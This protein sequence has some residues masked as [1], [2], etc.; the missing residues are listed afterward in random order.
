VE[1][2]PSWE[3]DSHS[4]SQIP[5]LLWNP[6]IHYRIHNSPPLVSDLSQM[7]PVHISPTYFPKI[8]SNII[9]SCTPSYSLIF[10]FSD[11]NFVRISHLSSACYIPCPPH[12]PWFDHPNNFWWSVQ[13]MKLLIM[14]CFPAKGTWIWQEIS[15]EYANYR[16]KL[17][18][19]YY[20]T[21]IRIIIP[22]PHDLPSVLFHSDSSSTKLVQVFTSPWL[23]HVLPISFLI[24][25]P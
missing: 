18:W 9:L 23:L 12:P 3:A 6:K 21:W 14:Q 8:H 17:D 19:Y 10:R 22:L 4:A 1:Q 5:R 15:R 24:Y 11:Q 16:M 13:V 25:S 7:N 2:S 20:R